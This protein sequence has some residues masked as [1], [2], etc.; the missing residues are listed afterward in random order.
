M[1][2]EI[3]R[4]GKL[5]EVDV[6]EVELSDGRIV[7]VREFFLSEIMKIEKLKSKE[8]KAKRQIQVSVLDEGPDFYDSLTA[9]DAVKL[10]K[11]IASLN[12]IEKN[13]EA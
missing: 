1:R 4:N 9:K 12:N 5:K 13:L 8:D 6:R 3:E 2:K 7:M 10:M 11:V